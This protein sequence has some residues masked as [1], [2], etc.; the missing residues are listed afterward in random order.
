MQADAP[1]QVSCGVLLVDSQGHLFMARATG[2]KHWDIPKGLQEPQESPE[3][4][5]RRE[6][7][8]ETGIVLSADTVL[9]DLG[10]FGYRPGKDLHLFLAR[11]PSTSVDL[12]QCQ[13]RSFFS[14]PL[15][16]RLTP[17]V[18]AFAWIPVEEVPHRCAKSLE[19]LFSQQRLWP[20]LKQDS[21]N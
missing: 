18:D 15:S 2:G 13:C 11:V 4:A 12:S 3:Q 21:W 10:R 6:L 16:G 5:A 9:Q 1:R 20:V 19:K 17:E 14:H 8:E 7:Q